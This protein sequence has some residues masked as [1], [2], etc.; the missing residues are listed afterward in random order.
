[1]L[2]DF[3]RWLTLPA[4]RRRQRPGSRSRRSGCLLWLLVLVIVLIVI[5]VLFGGFQKGAKVGGAG[6]PA[7]VPAAAA[8]AAQGAY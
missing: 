2:R 5:S 6:A 1:V 4:M 7:P 8:P 3:F